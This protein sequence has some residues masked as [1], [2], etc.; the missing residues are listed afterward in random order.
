MPIN[1]ANIA[2][3][4]S[5]SLSNVQWDNEPKPKAKSV[6][7]TQQPLVDRLKRQAGLTARYGLEGAGSLVDLL[8]TPVR[9][10]INAVLPE[11]R[12]LQPVSA[13]GSLADTL[14]LPQPQNA[15]ERVVG[16]ISRTIAGT[17]ATIGL[18]GLSAPTSAVG[19][20]VKSSL[21]SN[22]PTQLSASISGGAGSGLAREAGGGAIAQ[23]AGGLLGG[24][25]GAS[26]VKPQPTG[27][28]TQQMQNAPKDKLLNE[29]QDAGFYALPSDVKAGKFAKGL[30][31]VSGKFKSEESLSSKNQNVANG[32]TRKY[33]GLPESSPLNTDTFDALRSSYAEPYK[34]ASQLP[35]GQVSK[36]TIQ[37]ATG[38]T[39][40]KPVIKTGEQLVNEIKMARDDSRAAWKSYNSGQASNPTEIRQQAQRSDNLV[41]SL[42][43]EL[44]TLAK[45]NNQPELLQSLNEARRNI[46]K[47][48]TVEKAMTGENVIDYRKIGKM[49]DK[50]VP[51]DGDL[52]LA[53]KFA[54]E[55]PRVNKPVAYAPPAFT[56]P[57]VY[58][59]AIGA[60]VDVLT[61]VPFASAIP[62]ARVGSRYLMESKPF[63]QR[64]VQPNY[65]Q[66]TTPFVPYMGLLNQ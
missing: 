66:N 23:T 21:T 18:G 48:H 35:A 28:T 36:P 6:E 10:A 3:D 65:K 5:P 64:F 52:L 16:D 25:T 62:A 11:N 8:Q 24:M 12:Q 58:S 14:G 26:M 22:A 50:G 17:G 32:L 4:N 47:V 7:N 51:I 41:N 55:F 19:Q 54:K 61:G 53:G 31:T 49:I 40:T 57:D 59:S 44:D 42:E 15:T 27:L 56:L 60:G 34:L 30:E 9:G 13:G 45:V 46:A 43:K 33:L 63:Q 1:E 37:M 29:A 2:W 20:S 39:T 38:Q